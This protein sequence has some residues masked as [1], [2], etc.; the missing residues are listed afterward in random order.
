MYAEICVVFR[1][2]LV[3]MNREL[4]TGCCSY[5]KHI[6]ASVQSFIPREDML[7]CLRVRVRQE[8]PDTEVVCLKSSGK[9][10]KNIGSR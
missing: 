4:K 7:L 10:H 1:M 3:R 6:I 5:I 2:E 9:A 8:V